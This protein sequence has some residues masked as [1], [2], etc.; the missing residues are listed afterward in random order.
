VSIAKM[1]RV[2]EV[3]PQLSAAEREAK[4]APYRSV[5]DKYV[6]RFSEQ[7]LRYPGALGS[8]GTERGWAN[9]F[10]E[11]YVLNHGHLPDQK[12]WM[13]VQVDRAGYG[14]AEHD[15]A[16]LKSLA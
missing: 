7:S 1:K 15:F 9:L 2:T 11:V 8:Y 14:G 4:L 3:S 6:L 12:L 10:I 16:D 13:D 5:I